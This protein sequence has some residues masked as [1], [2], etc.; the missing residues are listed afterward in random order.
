MGT[1]DRHRPGAR[2]LRDAESVAQQALGNLAA[3]R[4][5]L[6]EARRK[7]KWIRKSRELHEA[8][9]AVEL[10]ALAAY[11]AGIGWNQIGDVL[12]I[13]RALAPESA[14][15]EI[16]SCVVVEGRHATLA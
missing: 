10:A 16:D 13:E 9:R 4:L 15:R 3:A 6:E 1:I 8:T 5:Q 11:R 2:R 7:A 12:G 14:V